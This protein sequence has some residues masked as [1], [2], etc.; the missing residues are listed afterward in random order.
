[1]KQATTLKMNRQHENAFHK[2]YTIVAGKFHI[3]VRVLSTKPHS[4][5]SNY[6]ILMGTTGS[7]YT[8]RR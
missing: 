1:M 8:E 6:Q 5:I 7:N 2:I 3:R 4:N